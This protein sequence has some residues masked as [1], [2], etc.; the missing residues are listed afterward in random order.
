MEGNFLVS[1]ANTGGSLEE[2]GAGWLF[3]RWAADQFGTGADNL[4]Q[5]RVR[6]TTF[7]QALV[8]TSQLGAAN[9]QSVAGESFSQL[10]PQ[11]QM[12]NYLDDLPGFTP[13]SD[14]LRYITINLRNQ[15]N[16][17]HNQ[18]PSDFPEPYPLRPDSTRTGV[19]SRS[20]TLRQGSGRH[21]RII[22]SAGA[23]SVQLLLT[24]GTGGGVSATAVPRVGL[25]RVR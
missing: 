12:A 2:R 11:W 20:G 13:S 18:R 6:G 1:P 14:R 10:V 8:Q 5:F 17:L 21:V 3:V 7:T 4:P 23:L 9:V 16:Q 22:Q 24:N 19:Y 15:F 25:V